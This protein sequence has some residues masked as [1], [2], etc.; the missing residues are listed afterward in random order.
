QAYYVGMSFYGFWR[1]SGQKDQEATGV[2]TWPL[3]AH[4]VSWVV[5]LV[6]S[7]LTARWLAA[8]TQAA[9]PFLDSL[10]TWASL[11]A[12]W[13]VA[14]AKLQNW[15]YWIAA[16]AVLVFLCVQQGKVFVAALFA[17]YLVISVFGFASWSKNY[18]RH[19]LAS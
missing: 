16:D 10:T 9:W 5:I 6:V 3:R 1:W 19:V 8:E 12:C 4:L 13:L 11:L 2:T 15:L 14:R 17:A 18:R 7:V